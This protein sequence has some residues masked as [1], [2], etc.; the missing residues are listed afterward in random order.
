[1]VNINID[2]LLKKWL[3]KIIKAIN[4]DFNIGSAVGITNAKRSGKQTNMNP[5][6]LTDNLNI[7]SDMSRILSLFIQLLGSK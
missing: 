4:I 1:M 5:L 6:N 2:K 7:T 3:P